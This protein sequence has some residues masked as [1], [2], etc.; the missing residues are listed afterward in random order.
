VKSGKIRYREQMLEGIQHAP[1]SI[2]KLYTGENT[3]KLVMRLPAARDG[4]GR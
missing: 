2:Q 4:G 1:G 3:G